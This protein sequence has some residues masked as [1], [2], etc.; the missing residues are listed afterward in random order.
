MAGIFES[1]QSGVFRDE[2]VLL[3]EYQPP[4]LMFRQEQ[5]RAIARCVQGVARGQPPQ[6]AFVFGPTGTGKTTASRMVLSEL[7]EFTERAVTAYVNC[8]ETY[9]RQAVYSTIADQ[10][11]E[12]LPKRGIGADEIFSRIVQR[13][14]Y[15][16]KA[17]IVVLDEADRVAAGEASSVLYEL[18][19]A[20][21]NHGASFGLILVSNAQDLA[22]GLDSRI[23][24]SLRLERVEFPRYLP[25]QLKDI[26][27]AR[28]KD[29]FMPGA[30]SGEIIGLCA[31]F[32]A[33]AGG[34]ARVA[35]EALWKAGR[36]AEKRGSKK[37]EESDVRASQ[38]QTGEW[39]RQQRLDGV[40]EPE[41]RLLDLLS[42]GGEV[43]SGEL[44]AK[45]SSL[46][47]ESE[48]QIRNYVNALEK[49][50]LVAVRESPA[51]GGRGKTRL[52]KIA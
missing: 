10:V 27:S 37:V 33:K 2:R 17:C 36:N 45:Y 32:G 26:L 34:D 14:K 31:A 44:Y 35:L 7:S 22:A 43:S 19:R 25:S 38:A 42:K 29:A 9:S 39:K 5:V 15:D 1:M 46:Y 3:P 11:G 20:G 50:R 16:R 49:R 51:Q 12:A 47:G 40:S 24:S 28:A 18:S 8:W 52:L 30:A 23:R 4:Q 41:R 48:R 13:L 21:E 6:N